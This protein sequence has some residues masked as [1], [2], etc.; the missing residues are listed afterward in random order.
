MRILQSP[1]PLDF[2][3]DQLS[4]FLAGSIE[5]GKADDWQQ[6]AVQ[7]L[8]DLDILLLNPRRASWDASIAQSLDN[9]F[10]REQVEWE[11]AAQERADIVSFYFA[12]NTQA[13]IT[14]L[15]FLTAQTHDRLLPGRLLAQGEYR[16]RLRTLWH[17]ASGDTGRTDRGDTGRVHKYWRRQ[18]IKMW[19]GLESPTGPFAREMTTA[20]TLNVGLCSPTN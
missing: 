9:P 13:P 19:V 4:L 12:P 1:A 2:Q 20:V 18:V 15:E 10:F 11:L 5:L 3:A 6:Q 17:Q 7:G 8:S 14:L 16:C